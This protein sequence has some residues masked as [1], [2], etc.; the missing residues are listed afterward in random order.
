MWGVGLEEGWDVECHVCS[1]SGMLTS[2][3]KTCTMHCLKVAAGWI[4]HPMKQV[5]HQVMYCRLLCQA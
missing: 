2:L 3:E 4:T 1:G 5:M